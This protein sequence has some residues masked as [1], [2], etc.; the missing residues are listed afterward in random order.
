MSKRLFSSNDLARIRQAKKELEEH[1]Q[2]IGEAMAKGAQASAKPSPEA[3][4]HGHHEKASAG[5]NNNIEEAE[6][7]IIDDDK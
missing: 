2:H 5:E 1:M 3:A 4:P 7:E 6:V